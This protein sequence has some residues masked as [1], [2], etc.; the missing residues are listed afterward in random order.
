MSGNVF[1]LVSRQ[2]RSDLPW[3]IAEYAGMITTSLVCV[4]LFFGGWHIPWV[5]LIWPNVF[6]YVPDGRP[7]VTIHKLPST[8]PSRDPRPPLAL[9]RFL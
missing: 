2:F 8:S 5:D 4:A 7:D 9:I 6:G 1:R 3:F